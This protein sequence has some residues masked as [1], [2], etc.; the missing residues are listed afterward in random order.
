MAALQRDPG[1]ADAWAGLADTYSILDH[2]PGVTTLP[3]AETYRLAAQ[4]AEKALSIDPDSHEAHAALGHILMHQGEFDTAERHLKRAIE[5]NPNDAM[6]RLWYSVLL[7]TIGRKD[8]ATVQAL[9][10]RELD[11][12]SPLVLRIGGVAFVY[13]GDPRQALEAAEEGLALGIDQRQFQRLKIRALSLLGRH[14]EALALAEPF[15]A[16]DPGEY[17]TALALAGR[18]ADA[19][20]A[21]QRA[22]QEGTAV[23]PPEVM[24]RAWAAAGDQDKAAEWMERI[25]REQRDFAR[26]NVD[27]PRH[28]A[29]DAFA[30]DPRYV[31]MRRQLGLS[32]D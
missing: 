8:E 20:A 22:E 21:L 25:V 14:A 32:S 31:A 9:R 15:A 27:L 1:F 7:R 18:D 17:A 16:E 12:L 3:P 5:L 11:P 13:S 30:R 2:R 23:L 4:A 28:P 29:F 6:A 26:A 10:A 24:V 19:R